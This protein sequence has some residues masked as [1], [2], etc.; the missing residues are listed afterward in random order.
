EAGAIVPTEDIPELIRQARMQWRRLVIAHQSRREESADQAGGDAVVKPLR[1]A[2]LI[3]TERF[4][5]A[6][7]TPVTLS[8][9]QADAAL[10]RLLGYCRQRGDEL[11]AREKTTPT[12][13]RQRAQEEVVR[14]YQAAP[15]SAFY[16][17]RMPTG[18][19]KTLAALRVGLEACRTGRAERIVYVAPY[20][21]ILSQAVKE[22]REA[23]ELE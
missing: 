5:H 22:M 13:L 9:Q 3:S 11:D 4:S 12:G 20:L 17:L 10:E 23:T 8:P 1:T 21:T 6:H 14:A 19:G 2:R 15:P 7:V 16:T 18:M